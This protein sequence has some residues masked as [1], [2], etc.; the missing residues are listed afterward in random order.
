M[1]YKREISEKAKLIN[2][3]ERFNASWGWLRYFIMRTE[4]L[5]DL[6]SDYS[7]H[8]KTEK[9]E[10]QSKFKIRHLEESSSD[11]Q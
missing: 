8:V 4:G 11:E 3:D 7:P 9:V 10:K 5:A 2:P 1:I 6:I